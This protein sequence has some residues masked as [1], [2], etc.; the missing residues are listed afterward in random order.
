M[1]AGLIGDFTDQHK[2]IMGTHDAGIQQAA[3]AD[4]AEQQRQ[5]QVQDV[6]A[7][8]EKRAANNGN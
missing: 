6:I 7:A 8:A 1:A 2:E 3:E 5:K 4:S